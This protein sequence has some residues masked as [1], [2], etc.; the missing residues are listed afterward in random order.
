MKAISMMQPYAWLFANG[1]L[2][3]DDRTWPTA[4]RGAIAI[5]AS[6]SFH[7]PYYDFLVA[8][9]S[10]QLP[11]PDQFEKGG[12]VGIAQLTD[13]TAPLPGPMTRLDLNRSHFGAPGHHGFV[14]E[15]AHPIALQHFRGKPGIF[16][17]P[18]GY[19]VD[20]PPAP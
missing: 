10:L 3:I 19:L 1:L 9:T 17:V 6:L 7:Q 12:F 14:L 15:R 11:R 8:N 5:H 20:R 16:D 2:R 13:C 4:Y 18:R